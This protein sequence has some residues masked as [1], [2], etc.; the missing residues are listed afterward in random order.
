MSCV[1]KQF[2][3]ESLIIHFPLPGFM[4]PVVF[5]H[6]DSRNCQIQNC[7]I[8]AREKAIFN[9]RSQGLKEDFEGSTPTP[10]VGRIGYPNVNVGLMSLTSISESAWKHDAPNYWA[11]HNY[12]VPKVVD[13]RSSL[14]NSR[15]KAQVRSS[16]KL[17]DLAQEIGIAQKPANLEVKLEKKPSLAIKYDSQLTAMGPSA[18]LKSAKLVSNPRVHTK[19]DKVV[20]D[21]DLKANEGI[22]YLYQS[23]FS[24]NV[25]SRMLSIGTLGVQTQ[26]KLVPTRWSI[27]ATDDSIGK[28]LIDSIE[29]YSQH[30]PAAYFGNYLGNYFIVCILPGLWSYELFEM[31]VPK[32]GKIHSYTTDWEDFRGRSSYAQN[33]TGGYYACRLA[34]LEKLHEIKRKGSALVLR[35]ISDEY[36]A[37]L[38]VWVVREATRKA[39]Q[40]KPI[41]FGDKDLL[42]TYVRHFA[43]KHFGANVDELLKRSSLLDQ[44]IVQKRLGEF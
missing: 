17:L 32:D 8:C 41:T 43:R 11:N 39:M 33:T 38:G 26:R 21:T 27:T 1:R 16:S 10:F 36:N 4:K 28:R 44:V 30:D 15:F 14:I 19:V 2:S 7:P 42:L 20:S 5:K 40:N 9:I 12:N 37:P 34:V 29:D 3:S 6:H 13:L 31:Y 35:F 22:T 23:G 18:S 25:L 24:E